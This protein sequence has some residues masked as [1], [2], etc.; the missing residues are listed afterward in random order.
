MIDA[1]TH[2]FDEEV[3]RTYQARA[4]GGVEKALT[5]HIAPHGTTQYPSLESVLEFAAQKPD[6]VV[7]AS[8]DLGGDLQTQAAML[9]KLFEEKKIVAL[10]LY[11]GYQHVFASD[12]SIIMFA[13]LCAKFK[14]PLIL[15]AG[16]VHDPDH[17]ALLRYAQPIHV[18]DLAVAVPDCT[19]VI[20][21]FGFPYILETANVAAK[22]SNVYIDFSGTLNDL[23][24]EERN[25]VNQEAYI[26]D[27]TKAFSYYP[28]VRSKV[29]FGTDYGGENSDL[30]LF[31]EYVDL[32]EKLFSPEEKE[33]VFSGLAKK[34]FDL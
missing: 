30:R 14:R 29:L 19:I 27:L 10:K 4:K 9:E 6:L 23:G 21:H 5:F 26:Q 1:H 17:V 15:H 12:P 31:E 22:N 11:L 2:I 7:V 24:S 32:T 3:Y 18:D 25:R 33:W 34:L 13:N 28:A 8:V 16:D 20:A